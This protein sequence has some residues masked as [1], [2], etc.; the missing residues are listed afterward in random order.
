MR[1]IEIDEEVFG[2]I[3]SR[4]VPY[5]DQN[6]NDTLRRIF[7]ISA[8]KNKDKNEGSVS[9]QE[10]LADLDRESRKKA[11]K[12]DIGALVS[13]GYLKDSEELVLVDYTRNPVSGTTAT[14]EGS[15]LRYN[16][17]SYSMSELAKRLL[18]EK[19]GYRSNSV[20]GPSHWMNRRGQTV[21]DLWSTYLTESNQEKSEYQ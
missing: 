8:N 6:P 9:I 4:A 17:K 10:I 16:G 3:Q 1:T 19:S 12:A 5:E 14:V 18:R 15:K 11:P 21:T 2:F 7:E 20:R 13:N